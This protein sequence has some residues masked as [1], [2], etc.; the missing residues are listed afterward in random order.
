VQRTC[1]GSIV[2]SKGR[3]LLVVIGGS[4]SMNYKT[5]FIKAK[6]EPTGQKIGIT[7]SDS[8]IDGYQLSVDV[9]KAI[10]LLATDGYEIVSMEQVISGRYQSKFKEA[11]FSGTD[12]GWGYGYSFTEGMIILARK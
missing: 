5:V 7:E 9:Q 11:G 10:S 4:I 3:S 2:G 1:G 12:G 6:F 8:E